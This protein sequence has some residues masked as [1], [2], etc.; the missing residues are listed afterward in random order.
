MSQRRRN[1]GRK[2]GE[3]RKETGREDGDRERGAE[4]KHAAITEAKVTD[5]DRAASSLFHMLVPSVTPTQTLSPEDSPPHSAGGDFM[6][7]ML[8]GQ[9][10]AGPCAP[11]WN[12]S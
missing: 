9:R 5:R 8:R 2:R 7:S 1:E 6:K 4:K 3:R 12:L 11:A 10:R